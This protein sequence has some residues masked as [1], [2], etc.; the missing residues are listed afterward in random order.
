MKKIAIIIESFYKLKIKLKI[1]IYRKMF[2]KCG[3]N[4]IF[5]PENSMFSYKT[6]TLGNNVFIGG[7]AYWSASESEILIGDYVMVGPGSK[8]IGGDHEAKDITI[9][10]MLQ[11]KNKDNSTNKTD[12]DIIIRNDVWLGSGV[13][14][15]K[16]VEIGQGAIVGAGSV[17]T[18]NVKPYTVVAGNPAIWIKNR[19]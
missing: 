1:I 17:V 6:V 13:I 15:L 9:P 7:M 11:K 2:K 19:F 10:M 14:I 3:E 5:N 18:K 4:A 8:I 16:G 12:K